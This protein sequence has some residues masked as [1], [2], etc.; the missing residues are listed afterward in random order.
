MLWTTIFIFYIFYHIYTI[1]NYQ[2]LFQLS[3]GEDIKSMDIFISEFTDVYS[4]PGLPFI[5]G[6]AASLLLVPISI[7]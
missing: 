3:V 5:H 4:L 6:R 7:D 2:S 1:I